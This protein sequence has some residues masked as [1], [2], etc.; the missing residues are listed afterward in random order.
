MS[1]TTENLFTPDCIRTFSGHYLDVFN[2]DPAKIVIEDIAHA[3]AHTALRRA[4]ARI[5]LCGTAQR[6]V[7]RGRRR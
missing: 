1:T 5:L 2:P 7:L 4:P 3:L 6:D